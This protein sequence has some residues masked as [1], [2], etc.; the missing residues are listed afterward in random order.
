VKQLPRTAT[1]VVESDQK[2]KSPFHFLRRLLPDVPAGL[3]RELMKVGGVLVDG[4]SDDLNRPL[5]SGAC[6][7]LNWPKELHARVLRKEP[8]RRSPPV[9]YRSER[10]L[11]VDKPAGLSV[12]PERRRQ[13]ATLLDALDDSVA[14][15]EAG[16]RVK[17]VHRIDKHTSGALLL[18]RDFEAKRALCADFLARRIKK[19]YLAVVRGRFDDGPI[20]CNE[21][22]AT[23]RKHALK[24]VIDAKRG[25]PSTTRFSVARRFDGF[26]LVRAEPITGRTHQIRVHLAHLGFPI[27]CD[28]LYGAAKEVYLSEWKLGYR[29]PRGFVERPLLDRLALHCE[30][31]EF[32]DPGTGE[33]VAVHAPLPPDLVSLLKQLERNRP[34]RSTRDRLDP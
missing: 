8:P 34:A 21:P 20:E 33:R 6:V 13:R 17:V 15:D 2:A 14:R 9:L 7:T 28:E 27:L 1:F 3:L 16:L 23:D 18:A 11:V 4:R 24:M 30:S 31:L 12:V 26:T 29:K 22:I 19:S 5:R 10:V 32:D 25:K